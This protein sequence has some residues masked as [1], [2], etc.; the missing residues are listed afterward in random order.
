MTN[1]PKSGGEQGVFF[2]DSAL[3]QA[4]EKILAHYANSELYISLGE[5]YVSVLK[6]MIRDGIKVGI[7]LRRLVDISVGKKT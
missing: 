4:T 5:P 1:A 7:E 6:Q 3:D 2:L